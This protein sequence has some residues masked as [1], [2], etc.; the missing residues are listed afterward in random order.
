M[1]APDGTSGEVPVDRV[2]DAVKA[3][4]RM[5]VNMIAPNGQ[6]GTI[7]VEKAADAMKAGF[8][9]AGP[10]PQ[11]NPN[12]GSG[13]FNDAVQKTTDEFTSRLGVPK[14]WSVGAAIDR[15]KQSVQQGV[16][17]DAQMA[18]SVID[19][20]KSG[21][22]GQA[23]KTLLGHLAKNSD[24]GQAA[25]QIVDEVKTPIQNVQKGEYAKAAG[26]V[27]ATGAKIASSIPAPEMAEAGAAKVGDVMEN[28]ITPSARTASRVKAVVPEAAALPD[29]AVT[30]GDQLFRAVAPTATDTGA[31]VNIHVASGDL[32]QIADEVNWDA[33]RGGKTSPDMRPRAV[34]AAVND[35]MGEMY[36]TEVAP[37]IA[38]AGDAKVTLTGGKDGLDFLSRNAGDA[39]VRAAAARMSSGSSNL[40]DAYTVA[41][42][43]NAELRQFE[44][45]SPDQQYTI[46]NQNPGINNLENLDKELSQNIAQTLEDR[47]IPG[48][49]NFERRYA[50]LASF[51]R[52]LGMRVN[53]AELERSSL[54]PVKTIGKMAMGKSGIAS[55]SQAAL[56]DLGPGGMGNML[57]KGLKGLRDSG[58][59]PQLDPMPPA[60]NL[61]LTSPG[62]A[63]PPAQQGSLPFGSGPAPAAPAPAAPAPAAPAAPAAPS[64]M[65]SL[66]DGL[67]ASE[68]PRPQQAKPLSNNGSGESAAST[69][70]MS[71]AARNKALGNKYVKYDTRSG[72][73]Q[74]VI[75]PRPEDTNLAPHEE[76]VLERKDG[77]REVVSS[78]SK[79]RPYTPK[80]LG[81][82]PGLMRLAGE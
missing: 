62:G 68:A 55:A 4:F 39:E 6:S 74:E 78:G 9:Q 75:G 14:D 70:A 22:Y 31:R 79:T 30:A 64:G 60:P 42:G 45:L 10:A 59:R 1:L 48:I 58:V 25:S 44:R 72:I 53:A 80:K 66:Y 34:L 36:Q 32:A 49:K 67:D 81:A 3:G 26:D 12:G 51:R 18:Q 23:A 46:R 69:E 5:G 28:G 19:S 40:Q 71:A 77:T 76:L 63:A 21:N 33:V 27:M 73:G 11:S 56:S 7:P 52:E 41:K 17:D 24:A 57:E 47:G 2:N 29:R 38:G 65:Q 35:H 43:A 20:V 82:K 13:A 8:K 37:K 50:A 16:T 61:K 15:T 54:N